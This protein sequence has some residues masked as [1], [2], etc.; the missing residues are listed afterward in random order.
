[1][2][3]HSLQD[4]LNAEKA[5]TERIEKAK[6]AAEEIRKKVT[7][8]ASA[9]DAAVAAEIESSHRRALE[10]LKLDSQAVRAK[11]IADAEKV[12]FGWREKYSQR[13]S[14]IIDKLCRLITG[15]KNG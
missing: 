13:S 7:A 8:D 11:A 14:D 12:I 9:I 2:S 10:K 3:E 1:M 6:E 15:E 4:I 5:A